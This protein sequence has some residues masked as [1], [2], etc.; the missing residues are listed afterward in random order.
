MDLKKFVEMGKEEGNGDGKEID[1]E[2]VRELGDLMEMG[3]LE[4]LS[5]FY[6]RIVETGKVVGVDS[7]QKS[8]GNKTKNVDQP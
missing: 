7:M 5:G 3:K 2:R 6:D 8:P 4:I 1:W